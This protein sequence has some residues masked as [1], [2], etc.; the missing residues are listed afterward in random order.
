MPVTLF[1]YVF[2]RRCICK[3]K[4]SEMWITAP[5]LQADELLCCH[6]FGRVVPQ[7][8]VT[9]TYFNKNQETQQRMKYMQM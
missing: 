9:V 3:L 2:S 7:T 6:I 1:F 5:S 4:P 8:A